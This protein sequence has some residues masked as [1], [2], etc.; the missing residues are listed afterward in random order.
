[1]RV[2]GFGF[3]RDAPLSSVIAA[4]RALEAPVQA[5]ATVAEKAERPQARQAA[6][7]LGLPLIAIPAERISRQPTPTMSSRMQARFGTGSLAE[8]AAL[9]ACG[10]GARLLVARRISAD[11][12]ATAA[13]AEGSAS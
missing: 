3:R 11:G 4:I 8:A 1:M 7:A 2:A 12:M 6:S 5:L 9:A 13:L 10:E